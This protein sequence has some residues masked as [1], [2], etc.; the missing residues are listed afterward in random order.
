MNK[1]NNSL[2]RLGKYFREVSVVVI[3][4]A[5]TLSA[6]YLI[7][8]RNEKRDMALYMS[9]IKM[10][11]EDNIKTFD[12][13]IEYYQPS[14]RYTEYLLTHDKNSLNKDTINN[15]ISVFYSSKSFSF[16]T[17]AFEMFKSSGIMRLINDKQLL[18]SIWD[19]YADIV[20]LRESL[21]WGDKLKRDYMI[22]EVSMAIVNNGTLELKTK[23]EAPMY[24]FYIMNI[25]N[26]LLK[27]C[28]EALESSKELLEKM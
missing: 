8:L 24:S 14:I 28:E 4:V 1:T 9:A 2:N 13:A 27:A 21:D 18:L 5:I 25:S 15:Y 16:K 23:G 17:N 20:L 26:S 12:E 19:V 6:S 10:E 7:S 22:K 3:G 11:M